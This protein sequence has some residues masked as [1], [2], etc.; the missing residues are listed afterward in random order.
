MPA[1]LLYGQKE[2]RIPAPAGSVILYLDGAEVSTAKSIQLTAGRNELV[3]EGISAM[4]NPSSIQVKLDNEAIILSVSHTYNYLNLQKEGVRL[5]QLRDSL[6]LLVD[7]IGGNND[8]IG[9]YEAERGM[10]NA[11]NSHVGTTTGGA[12]AVNTT[13]LKQAADF[14]RTRTKEINNRVTELRGKN[15]EINKIV[16]RINSELNELNEQNTLRTADIRVLVESKVNGAHNVDLKYLVTNAGWVPSYDLKAEDVGMPIELKYNAKVFNNTNVDW[17]DVKIKLSTADPTQS[18]SKPALKPWYVDFSYDNGYNNDRYQNQQQQYNLYNNNNAD[19]S[20]EYDKTGGKKGGGPNVIYE[21]IEISQ[22]S[23]EFD[24]K[25]KYS[26]PSDAKPYLV[27][28]TNYKL[29]ATYR[30]Y[31]APKVDKDAFLLARITKWESLDL[32]EG[33]ANVYFGG[34]FVGQSYIQPRSMDDTLDLSLG[35]DKKIIVSRTKTKDL[36]NVKTIGSSKRESYGYEISIKNNHKGA[37]TIDVMDQLPVSRNTDI[38]IENANISKAKKDDAT[39]ELKWNF[40]IAPGNTEKVEL[41]YVIKYPKSKAISGD[42]KRK[43]RTAR[44]L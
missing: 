9:A 7:R 25:D 32:V 23:A 12:T 8:E 37:V 38:V 30:H 29:E 20:K 17:K 31:C 21:E 5:K 24:I 44:F 19:I 39:G 15:D 4:L 35:R 34:T 36:T 33:P 10:L 11:S 26:V 22:L 42:N 18:A 43:M 40:T 14:Y 13:E 16:T 3:F 2:Q 1:S 28:I 6:K 27:E 41:S